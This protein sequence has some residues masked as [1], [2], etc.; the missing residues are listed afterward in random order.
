M[1]SPGCLKEDFLTDD[2]D[3]AVHPVQW[4]VECDGVRFGL[5]RDDGPG[6]VEDVVDIV[7]KFDGC[8]VSLLKSR[9]A[10]PSG[11]VCIYVTA[12]GFDGSVSN[13][14]KELGKLG[15]ILYFKPIEREWGLPVLI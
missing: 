4:V 7:A 8:L 5:V 9:P 11:P 14:R 3:Q 12:T 1:E 10:E 2:M 13:L 6:S 15:Q